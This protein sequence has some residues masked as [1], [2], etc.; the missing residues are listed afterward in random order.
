[1]V[2]RT[3]LTLKSSIKILV[4]GGEIY[5]WLILGRPPCKSYGG[6]SSPYHDGVLSCSHRS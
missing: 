5:S 3:P 4:K 2:V 1:M 6:S